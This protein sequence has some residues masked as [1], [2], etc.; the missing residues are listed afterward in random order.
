MYCVYSYMFI[1]YSKT[2]AVTETSYRGRGYSTNYY[3]SENIKKTNINNK[4][5]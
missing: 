1:N 2:E 4:M 5:V 3:T